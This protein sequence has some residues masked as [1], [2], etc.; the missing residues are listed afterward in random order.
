MTQAALVSANDPVY[1]AEISFDTWALCTG[2]HAQVNLN[3]RTQATVP[4]LC[5]TTQVCVRTLPASTSM[6]QEGEEMDSGRLDARWTI[7]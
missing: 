3:V 7:A 2:A 1:L 6:Y 5:D 4:H